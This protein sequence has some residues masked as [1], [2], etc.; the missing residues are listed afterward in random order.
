MFPMTGDVPPMPD[1]RPLK[2]RNWKMMS[3]L[4]TRL[5]RRGVTPNAISLGGLAA[6]VTAGGGL[7]ATSYPLNEWA[8]RLLYLSAAAAVQFRLL[9][10]LIDGMVAVEGGMRSPVGELFNEV[11]DRISDAAT[12]VGAGYAAMSVPWL[13]WLAAVL[14]VL[15]AY[16]RAVGKSVG[17]G[18]DYRGPMA[19]QQRMA[20]VTGVCLWMAAT[21]TWLQVVPIGEGGS[22]GVMAIGLGVISAGAVATCARRLARIAAHLRAAATGV[23]HG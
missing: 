2:S 12:L 22:V 14:A 10:N 11:P 16:V 3:V 17:A 6:A 7:V 21:P 18:S 13:G 23:E 5:A 19:K 8:I 4:A 15:T 20:V 9:C 1:R